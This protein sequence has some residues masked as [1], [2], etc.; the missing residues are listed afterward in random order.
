MSVEK[1]A[2]VVSKEPRKYG[3]QGQWCCVMLGF[4]WDK[5]QEMLVR[6]AVKNPLQSLAEV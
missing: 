3:G 6:P 2:N 5:N 1:H 4:S